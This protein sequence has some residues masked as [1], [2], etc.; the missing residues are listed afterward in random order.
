MS[1]SKKRMSQIDVLALRQEVAELRLELR[2]LE[3]ATNSPEA[4]MTR[5]SDDVLQR[6]R[7]VETAHNQIKVLCEISDSVYQ[8]RHSR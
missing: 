1:M 7:A 2:K 4:R 3:R 6:L 8:A 5:L